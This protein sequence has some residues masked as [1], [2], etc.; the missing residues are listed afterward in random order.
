MYVLLW[1]F[2]VPAPS[3]AEV[4]R[5]YSSAG[6]WT[7]LFQKSEGYLGSELYRDEE[8][9][10]R[11]ISL[12]RWDSREA[13]QRFQAEHAAEY[14]ALDELCSRLTATETRLGGLRRV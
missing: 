4:E 9:A 3:Q 12:D 8:A 10:G 5:L 6:P 2:V 7:E 11:Y 13:Y 14:A 1:E